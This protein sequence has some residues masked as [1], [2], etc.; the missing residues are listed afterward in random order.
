[1]LLWNVGWKG[2]GRNSEE[3]LR[4]KRSPVNNYRKNGIFA[5]HFGN[6]GNKSDVSGVGLFKRAGV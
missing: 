2:K 5:A 6:R 4:G 3:K 1:L